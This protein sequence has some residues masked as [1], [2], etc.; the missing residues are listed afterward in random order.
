[1]LVYVLNHMG[2]PLMPYFDAV[3]I[4]TGDNE[5]IIPMAEVYHK[6]HVAKGDYQQ[7]KDGKG[8]V[9]GKRSSGYFAI[10]NIFG[11]KVH[12]SANVK[13]ATVRLT[14]RTTTLTQRTEA[15]IPLGTKVPSILA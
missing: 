6:R 7:T 12:A 5:H 13:K 11:E 14:A 10:E 3:S 2:K 1:M 15:A 4:C 9:Q 8:F